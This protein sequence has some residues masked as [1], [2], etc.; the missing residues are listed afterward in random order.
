[1]IQK[2]TVLRSKIRRIKMKDETDKD[3]TKIH[4]KIIKTRKRRMMIH[5][6][7]MQRIIQIKTIQIRNMIHI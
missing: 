7:S 2:R 3:I 6:K 4:I 1:M 5:M